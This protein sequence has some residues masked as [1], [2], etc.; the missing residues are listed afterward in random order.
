M[1]KMGGKDEIMIKMGRRGARMGELQ[2]RKTTPSAMEAER[3]GKGSSISKQTE[4][5]NLI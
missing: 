2:G 3:A 1:G 5:N 4:I